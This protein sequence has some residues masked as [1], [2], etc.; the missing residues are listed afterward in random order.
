MQVKTTVNYS[1]TAQL[2]DAISILVFFSQAVNAETGSVNVRRY[3]CHLDKAGNRGITKEPGRT[4]IVQTVSQSS[5]N[6][7]SLI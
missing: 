7:D 2:I 1:E 6:S 5:G 3:C 4:V